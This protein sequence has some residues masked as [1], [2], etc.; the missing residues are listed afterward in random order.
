MKNLFIFCRF[1]SI[2]IIIIG[3]L[4]MSILSYSNSDVQVSEETE[5]KEHFPEISAENAMIFN[6]EIGTI[7]FQKNIDEKIY[8]GFLSRLMTCILLVESEEDLSQIITISSEVRNQT[9]QVSSANLKTNEKISLLDLLK[10]VLVANSQEAAIAIAHH[11][12][13]DTEKFVALMNNR[14]KELNANNTT[15]T[16]PHGYWSKYTTQ[17]TTSRDTALIISQALK[18]DYIFEYSDKTFVNISVNEKNRPLYT[19]NHLI[20]NSSQYNIKQAEG[21]SVYYDERVNASI[22]TVT[23]YKNMRLVSLVTSS[24]GLL[25][26]Y[27]DIKTMVEFSL[28]EYEYRKLIKQNAPIKEISVKL[29]KNRD[30][31]T[32]VAEDTIEFTIPKSVSNDEMVYIYDL[33]DSLTAPVKKGDIIGTVTIEYDGRLY[34]KTN[35]ISPINVDIDYI[36]SYSI[37]INNF[38]K[39]IVVQIIFLTVILLFIIYIII[40]LLLNRRKIRKKR[41]KEK[42]R[43]K[44]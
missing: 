21:I 20:D 42:G 6:V 12:S 1:L 4:N 37:T 10:C 5:K 33:P 2:L 7:L 18:L 28:K 29:A 13:G 14:A 9:P 38:F 19:R 17:L 24:I 22:A 11:I 43:V 35:L 8:C 3:I 34:G 32:V 23:V 41:K 15:F 44:F 39:N 31:L 27:N 25:S 40:I 26:G 36:S 30:F 16:N